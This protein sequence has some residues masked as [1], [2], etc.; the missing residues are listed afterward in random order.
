MIV[1]QG[2]L[3]RRGVVGLFLTAIVAGQ[4]SRP[5]G[6][7][8]KPNRTRL[9]VLDAGEA[10][11]LRAV[12]AGAGVAVIGGSGV[13]TF[14]DARNGEVRRT[15]STG[16][17]AWKRDV[18]A[19]FGGGGVPT[20]L[21]G[22]PVAVRGEEVVVVDGTKLIEIDSK[23]VAHVVCDDPILGGATVVCGTK[24]DEA[25]LVGT[26]KG[27][28]CLIV[29]GKIAQ[30]PDALDQ[31]VLRLAVA[32]DRGWCLC[33]GEGPD[34]RVHDVATL[35]LT[36]KTG[37]HL[38]EPFIHLIDVSRDG[39]HIAVAHGNSICRIKAFSVD[40]KGV[41][42]GFDAF[43]KAG[44]LC[45]TVAYDR[46]MNLLAAGDETGRVRVFPSGVGEEKELPRSTLIEED[47][48]AFVGG[49]VTNLRTGKS[50]L[51]SDLGSWRVDETPVRGVCFADDDKLVVSVDRFGNVVGRAWPKGDVKW[52]RKADV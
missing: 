21:R 40:D 27:L 7:E 49:S 1:A 31:P 51:V 38:G 22:I 47:D 9:E 23:G 15:V 37:N 45:T 34:W 52:T 43:R 44:G 3:R 12:N 5:I 2:P 42:T 26:R 32:R 13:V 39:G 19:G 4:E 11:G 46:S 24:S 17:R 41:V 20:T 28:L 18:D 14:L 29:S 48:G 50:L 30:A 8:S 36:L 35:R 6:A 33:A 10:V 16:V 25:V